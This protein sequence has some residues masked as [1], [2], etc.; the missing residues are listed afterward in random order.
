VADFTSALYLGLEHG[1]RQLAEWDRLTLGKPAALESPPGAADVER[2]LAALVGCEQA[3]LA[4]STLHAFHDLLSLLSRRGFSLFVDEGL[5]PI[6]MWGVERAAALGATVTRFPRHDA[7]A[8][9]LAIA[10][11]NAG[12]PLVVADGFCVSCG[13]TSPLLSYLACVASRDGLVVIDDTQA[14]GMLGRR[15]GPKAPYGSGGGGSLSHL[16]IRDPR[17]MVVSSL[18][19]AFGAPVAMVAGSRQAIAEFKSAS[20]TRVHCSP[21]SLASIAAAA[22]ALAVNARSGDALRSTLARR[23]ARLRQGLGPM[24]GTTGV[25]PVQHVRLPAR[26][27]PMSVHAALLERGVRTVLTRTERA[28]TAIKS[29]WRT[30]REPLRTGGFN[31]ASSAS[32]AFVLTAR[33]TNDDVDEAVDALAEA[34]RV[35]TT[36]GTFVRRVT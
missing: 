6:G 24:T 19:K 33:H 3:V 18:A 11:T 31:Q 27:D 26:T 14:L 5:Y 32:I 25:F 35:A 36:R 34:T 28:G 7:R 29:P 30:P 22:H 4:P 1:S 10:D 23:V 9:W 13:T 2:T 12:R 17:V 20:E 16:G 15:P 8:L 21:P